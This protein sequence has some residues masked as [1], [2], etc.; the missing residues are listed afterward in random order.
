MSCA[1]ILST[2]GVEKL[3]RMEMYNKVDIEYTGPKPFAFLGA[4]VLSSL[5]AA[6]GARRGGV[7]G[8]I[9]YSVV[10]A[11][12]GT[13]M[14]YMIDTFLEAIMHLMYQGLEVAMNYGN[15]G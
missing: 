4:T 15:Q 12:A 13:I 8:A 1:S 5:G 3:S 10:Y 6:T 14:G 11:M 2:K 9:A 7:L